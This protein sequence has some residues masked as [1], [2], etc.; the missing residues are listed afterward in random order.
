MCP[1]ANDNGAYLLSR[2]HGSGRTRVI[3][4]FSLWREKKSRAIHGRLRG[5]G[6][7]SPLPAGRVCRREIDRLTL[8][9]LRPAIIHNVLNARVPACDTRTQ[10]P[11][12]ASRTDR[13]F[14]YLWAG[15]CLQ[16]HYD[17]S[18]RPCTVVGYHHVL[19]TYITHARGI[20]LYTPV[21]G[22]VYG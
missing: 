4:S 12:R 7:R 20:R 3:I 19:C 1:G 5:I 14:F 6:V 8:S 13:V 18:Y 10:Q 9:R 2:I 11:T 17:P 22:R 21:L 16:T 15:V